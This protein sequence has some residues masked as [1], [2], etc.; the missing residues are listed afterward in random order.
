VRE[1]RRY[2]VPDLATLGCDGA[3][4][5]V[6]VT[7]RLQPGRLSDGERPVG[8]RVGEAA[9]GHVVGLRGDRVRRGQTPEQVGAVGAAHAAIAMGQEMT[10][11]VSP[12]A[13]LRDVSDQLEMIDGD[14]D[15][16]VV[17]Q[18]LVVGEVLGERRQPL[19]LDDSVGAPRWRQV[20]AA[21]P[22]PPGSAPIVGDIAK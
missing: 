6:S 18:R 19:V 9:G 16:V 21:T 7:E 20:A 4:E 8:V 22:S 17:A 11:D 5:G 10:G 1:E 3:F 2:G 12:G 14:R 15:E 13:A